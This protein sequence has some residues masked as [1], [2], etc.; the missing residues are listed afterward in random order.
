[1]FPPLISF[2]VLCP[3]FASLSRFFSAFH[4]PGNSTGVG[5][6]RRRDSLLVESDPKSKGYATRL[7]SRAGECHANSIPLGR[8][9]SFGSSARCFALCLRVFFSPSVRILFPRV[10]MGHHA[11]VPNSSAANDG[12]RYKPALD[13]TYPVRVKYTRRD[14]NI[15][16]RKRP[17]FRIYSSCHL[18]LSF[19]FC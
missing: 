2:S 4:W 11:A 5:K 9:P 16:S 8:D 6:G 12:L 19:S 10:A 15:I 3:S 17:I 7:G 14:S 1:M 13:R 18:S